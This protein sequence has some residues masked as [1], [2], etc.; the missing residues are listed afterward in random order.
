MPLV[1]HEEHITGR[2]VSMQMG[3]AMPVW[4]GS[5]GGLLQV[6][7]SQSESLAVT[8]LFWKMF[9]SGGSR[10]RV[11]AHTQPKGWRGPFLAAPRITSHFYPSPSVDNYLL[12][13]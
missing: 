9:H 1:S 10:C 5:P 2:C 3:P 8:L 7:L 11:V 13:T 6:L 12:S 4:R